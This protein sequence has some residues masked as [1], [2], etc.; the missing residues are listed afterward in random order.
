MKFRKFGIA[1]IKRK[2]SGRLYQVF[3]SIL[4]EPLAG[5]NRYVLR[6]IHQ[7]WEMYT[8]DKKDRNEYIH[9]WTKKAKETTRKTLV[10]NTFIAYSIENGECLWYMVEGNNYWTCERFPS[11][12]YYFIQRISWE[13]KNTC[14]YESF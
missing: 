5:Q 2:K 11:A 12:L 8:T 6:C 3:S 4:N 9:I 13:K 7:S 1:C 10:W 14:M